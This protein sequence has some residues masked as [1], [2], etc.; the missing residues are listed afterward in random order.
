MGN[1]HSILFLFF[2]GW[3][4]I[5]AADWAQIWQGLT[6]P[7]RPA[8]VGPGPRKKTRL[9][10]GPSSGLGLRLAGRVW[11]WKNT[12]RTQPIAIPK[13][14]LKRQSQTNHK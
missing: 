2:F 13:N 12:A 8:K 14:H 3:A 6:G 5:W 11:V 7:A 4:T 10:N 1:G 9:V